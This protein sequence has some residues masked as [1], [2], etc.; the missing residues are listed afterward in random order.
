MTPEQARIIILENALVQA[1][2]TIEFLHGCLMQPSYEEVVRVAVAAKQVADALSIQRH[3]G[4]T[5]TCVGH[6]YGH[7]DQ[8][9]RVLAELHTLV[10]MPLICHHSYFA[11]A[12]GQPCEA[13]E[14]AKAHRELLDEAKRV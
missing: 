6:G 8:T 11:P 14:Q 4:P 1:I 9:E 3:G 5:T 10:T 12:R 2:H 7:P 13:C